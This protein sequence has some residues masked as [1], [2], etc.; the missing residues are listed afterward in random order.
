MCEKRWSE[1]DIAPVLGRFLRYVQIDTESSP[2]APRTQCPST[3]CQKDLAQLL[4]KDLREVG[5]EQVRQDEYSY[6]YGMIRANG[7]KD[8]P[9]IGLIAHMDTAP[10]VSG[11]GVRPRV[12]EN[13]PGG[14]ILLNEAAGITMLRKEF[15][16]LDTFLGQDLVVTDG[17]TLLGADD[18]AG[19]AEILQMAQVLRDHPEIPHGEIWIAFTPDEEIGRG[20]DHFDTAGFPV[21]FAYTVDGGALGTYSYETFNAY[22]AAVTISGRSVHPGSA[23]GRMRSAL[24]IGM[25]FD[26]M[27]PVEQRPAYTAEREGFYHLS[28]FQGDVEKAVLSY[29]VR[30]HD[31]GR[32]AEKLA[33]LE[34]IS[35]YLNDRYGAGTVELK[36]EEQYRNMAEK[37]APMFSIVELIEKSMERQGISPQLI[38]TR[39]GTDGSRLSF[40]G[41]PCPNICTGVSNGHSRYEFVSVQSM[42]K[43]TALLI[44]IVSGFY[45][46]YEEMDL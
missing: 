26:R 25:E 44:E 33:F 17:T 46:N 9:K 35:R 40:M 39:G 10:D 30:D 7:D 16:Q 11:R 15:P 20:V 43:I 31:A 2:R 27:L 32:M 1:A 12:V 38:V 21:D 42:K 3:D 24:H 41:I 45:T 28:S 13:Y 36:V 18:K 14:D 8:V 6:V 4:A 23:K 19:A 37:I 5:A 34:R 22:S 29:A